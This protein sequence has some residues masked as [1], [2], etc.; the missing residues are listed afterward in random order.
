MELIRAPRVHDNP[1]PY[2]RRAALMTASQVLAAVRPARLASSMLLGGPGAGMNAGA[3]AGHDD[4]LLARLQWLQGW[5]G[6]VAGADPD[7]NCRTM[8]AACR[9]LHAGLAANAMASLQADSYGS[10][11]GGSV[12]HL[13]G[14]ASTR[15][16][17]IALP[18]GLGALKL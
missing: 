8:A 2:V 18:H 6:A 16:P 5:T 12:M 9:G 14:E 11:V 3:A 15:G 4:G 17:D 13:P 7:E 10:E 1:E